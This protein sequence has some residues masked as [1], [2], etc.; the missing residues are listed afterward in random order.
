MPP[1]CTKDIVVFFYEFE[2]LSTFN[3][4][5]SVRQYQT[6]KVR[7]IV[8]KKNGSTEGVMLLNSSTLI[9]CDNTVNN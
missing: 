4:K 3:L 6:L 8:N 9:Y 5:I 1:S 7:L 2:I